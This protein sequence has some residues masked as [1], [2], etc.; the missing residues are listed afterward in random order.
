MKTV[1]KGYQSDLDD[2]LIEMHV[3][4]EAKALFKSKNL[5]EYWSNINTAN[6]YQKFRAT[7]EPFIHAFPN[8]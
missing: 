5:S 8:S 3:D 7:A 4:H 6:K 2:E 1:N